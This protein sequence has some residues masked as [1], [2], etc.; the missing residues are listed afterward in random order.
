MRGLEGGGLT[1]R[2]IE[3]G[4]GCGYG[5]VAFEIMNVVVVVGVDR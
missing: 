5:Q 2:N 4:L 3:E 1:G